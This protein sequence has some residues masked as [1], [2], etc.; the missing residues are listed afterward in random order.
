M[1]S[2]KEHPGWEW[3]MKRRLKNCRLWKHRLNLVLAWVPFF[4]M[5]PQN[6][7]LGFLWSQGSI[8]HLAR[9]KDEEWVLR[10]GLQKI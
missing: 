10:G 4:L 8:Q 5:E 3:L 1:R 9:A 7:L 2:C 6:R